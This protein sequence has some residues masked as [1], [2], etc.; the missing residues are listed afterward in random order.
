M[1]GGAA[2]PF[3]VLSR[4]HRQLSRLAIEEEDPFN[5]QL[6]YGV[7]CDQV[8]ATYKY[9]QCALGFHVVSFVGVQCSTLG[10]INLAL[11]FVVFLYFVS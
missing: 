2:R 4:W 3:S 6:R 10:Y 5:L 7:Q 8:W 11:D 1:L 9:S